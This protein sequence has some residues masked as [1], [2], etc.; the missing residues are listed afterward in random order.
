MAAKFV[1]C[2]LVTRESASYKLAATVRIGIGE[3]MMILAAL[4]RIAERGMAFLQRAFPGVSLLHAVVPAPPVV[5][6]DAPT[7]AALSN[8]GV[9]ALLGAIGVAVTPLSPAGKAQFGLRFIDVIAEGGHVLPGTR[10]QV[11]ELDDHRIVVREL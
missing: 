7:L 9:V 3:A 11:V 1:T 5:K 6:A 8:S 2:R 4:E 10:I